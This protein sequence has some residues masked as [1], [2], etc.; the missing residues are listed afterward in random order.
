MMLGNW[1]HQLYF[2][3]A[4]ATLIALPILADLFLVIPLYTSA[5]CVLS[6]VLVATIYLMIEIKSY[7]LRIELRVLLFAT[8]V[9]AINL[10]CILHLPLNIVTY[11]ID[12]TINSF[13][14]D[15][16]II[17]Y[18]LEREGDLYILRN[19][20][21]GRTALV[22]IEHEEFSNA[23]MFYFCRLSRGWMVFVED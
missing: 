9:I 17:S 4:T 20:E 3:T 13:D 18:I 14:F 21:S 1:K 5:I 6:W 19:T 22:R 10:S 16:S 2:V 12:G 15:G 8:I 11:F 23:N 7:Q